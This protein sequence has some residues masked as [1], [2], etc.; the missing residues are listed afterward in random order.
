MT[1]GCRRSPSSEVGCLDPMN[2][3]P[4]YEDHIELGKKQLTTD[5]HRWVQL[6]RALGAM[7]EPE[8]HQ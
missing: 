8:A 5:H 7:M 1:D 3:T 6:V 2:R 4:K